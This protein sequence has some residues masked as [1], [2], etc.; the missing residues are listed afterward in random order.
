MLIS[1][2][3]LN[4]HTG[5]QSNSR[6][7]TNV[8]INIISEA[9]FNREENISRGTNDNMNAKTLDLQSTIFVWVPCRAAVIPGI[10][11]LSRK[12]RQTNNE[13][14]KCSKLNV[15]SKRCHQG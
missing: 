10:V 15:T 8:H 4:I 6:L 5:Q 3:A 12:H 13:H 11:A 1:N 14:K 2:I 7:F 9:C